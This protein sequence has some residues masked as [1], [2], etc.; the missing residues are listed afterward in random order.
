[1]RW[2]AGQDLQTNQKIVLAKTGTFKH[3]KI[4]FIVKKLT[5]TEKLCTP[6]LLVCVAVGFASEYPRRDMR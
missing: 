2:F 1:L 6:A 4:R 3:A 5:L